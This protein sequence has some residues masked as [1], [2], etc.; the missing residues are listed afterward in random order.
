MILCGIIPKI[1]INAESHCFS[2]LSN[3]ARLLSG[4][5][6]IV[7]SFYLEMNASELLNI[8]ITTAGIFRT[9]LCSDPLQSLHKKQNNRKD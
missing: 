4:T 7:S 9:A 3:I 5:E 8:S 6:I 1:F 2:L